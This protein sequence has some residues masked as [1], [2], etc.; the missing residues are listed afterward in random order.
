MQRTNSTVHYVCVTNKASS[1]SL[2]YRV[3]RVACIEMALTYQEGSLLHICLH[4][5]KSLVPH[6]IRVCVCVFE[7]VRENCL[8]MTYE[9]CDVEDGVN[10]G[11]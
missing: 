5:C 7:R 11:P 4:G 2:T 1:S 9:E 3:H 8:F 10:N 6:E